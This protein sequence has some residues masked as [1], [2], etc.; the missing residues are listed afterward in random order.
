MLGSIRRP[1][2]PE[3]VPGGWIIRLGDL[4]LRGNP[5]VGSIPWVSPPWDWEG[6]T[7]WLLFFFGSRTGS[8]TGMAKVT[9]GSLSFPFFLFCFF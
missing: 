1:S 5:V 3:I 6:G 8:F 2:G 4:G 7:S 9:F